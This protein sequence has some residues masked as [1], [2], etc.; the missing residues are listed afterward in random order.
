MEMLQSL[1]FHK[2]LQNL[3]AFRSISQTSSRLESLLCFLFNRSQKIAI[4]TKPPITTVVCE[5]DPQ[6]HAVKKWRDEAHQNGNSGWKYHGCPNVIVILEVGKQEI[7][8]L[9]VSPLKLPPDPW[10]FHPFPWASSSSN[11][12]AEKLFNQCLQSLL[13]LILVA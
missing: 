11:F 10:H 6:D 12:V 3:I 7:E 5:L 8:R 1:S 4:G 9:P 2:Y 13:L